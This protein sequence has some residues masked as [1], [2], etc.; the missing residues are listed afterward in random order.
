MADNSKTAVI[1]GSGAG[2]SMAALALAQSGRFG[3]ITVLEKGPNYYRDLEGPNFNEMT[4]AFSNDEIKFGQRAGS[5][6]AADSLIDADLLLD[7]RSFRTST[8]VAREIVGDVQRLPQ[9]VGG[10][11]THSDWK[12]RRL[13]P[14]DF[15]LKTL[16]DQF[17]YDITNSTTVDWPISYD[18]LEPFYALAEQIIGVQGP[19]RLPAPFAPR[20]SGPYPMP[21]G[22]PQYVALVVAAGAR[23]LGLS[24]FPSPTGITSRPYRGRPACNDCGFDGGFACPIGAKGTP[25]LTALR[26]AL[27]TGKVSIR[28]NSHVFRLNM[29]NTG[30]KVESVAFLDD[31]GNPQELAADIIVLAASSIESARLCLLSG[32]SHPLL[33][34]NLMFHRQTLAIGMFPQ[35]LH[36]HRG[37][38][39]SF[40]WDDFAGP[41]KIANY[42]SFSSGGVVLPRGGTVEIGGG[43][44]VISEGQLYP[45]GEAHKQSMRQSPLREHLAVLTMQGEDLPQATNRVDLDP[46]LR[47]SHGLRVA[48][49]TYAGHPYE[50]NAAAHYQPIMVDVLNAA[51]ALDAIPVTADQQSPVPASRHIMGTLRMGSDPSSSVTDA[52]GKFHDVANLYVADGSVFP[53]SGPMNPSLTIMALGYRT[54]T[55]AARTV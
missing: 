37:R 35:Q 16:A 33:G 10:G 30:G 54:G 46:D 39:S 13:R 24:P 51:G 25:A 5:G 4:V 43:M 20:R 14:A 11:L 12:A 1:I 17:G 6:A 32:F 47:D 41:A 28:P 36:A 31:D 52:N 7:P 21:P 26:D 19:A 29:S 44:P 48:R 38:T 45:F 15:R 8:G 34:A 23:Q 3:R 53:T 2:G 22:V 55:L 49:I 27:L 40:M 50:L 9:L 18:D 42:G